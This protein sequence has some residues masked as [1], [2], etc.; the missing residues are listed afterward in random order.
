MIYESKFRLAESRGEEG[1][2][3]RIDDSHP[4]DFFIGLDSGRR[5]VMI[6]CGSRPPEPPTLSSIEVEIRTR[7]DGRWAMILRLVRDD[8]KPLF[9][10]LVEDFDAATRQQPSD[11]GKVVIAR[12]VRW[13]NLL[14][15]GSIGV[16]EDHQLRGLCAEL[17]FL[18]TEAVATFGPAVGVAGWVGPYDAPKDFV[19]DQVEVEIKAVHRQPRVIQISSLEQLSDSKRPLFLWTKE[20]AITEVT[21]PDPHSVQALIGR[22]R[23]TLACDHSAAEAFESRLRAAGYEDRRE[24][25]LRAIRFGPAFCYRVQGTF[26]RVQRS[27][28]PPGVASAVY[29]LSVPSL[30][31]HRV[32]SW[33][34][35]DTYVQ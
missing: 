32:R 17:D 26:P 19:F 5:A 8:L 3:S 23:E 33:K 20:V 4:V 21:V 31:D 25:D 28:V 29:E 1:V 7:Q 22:I 24:Y 27:E 6:V 30:Q 10:T 18:M 12:L 35:T 15:R 9:S 34:E 16:L 13:Q 14:S 2:Y 11:P